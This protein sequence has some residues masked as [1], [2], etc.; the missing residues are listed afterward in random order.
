MTQH[1]PSQ[2]LHLPASPVARPDLEHLPDADVVGFF[3]VDEGAWRSF[4]RQRGR[5]EDEQVRQLG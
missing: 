2:G 5:D 4:L 3:E 1:K